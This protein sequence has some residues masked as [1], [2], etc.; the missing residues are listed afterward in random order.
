M[1]IKADIIQ[2]FI[3]CFV[4]LNENGGVLFGKKRPLSKFIKK[5]L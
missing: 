1:K 3:L 5:T 4:F 2:L